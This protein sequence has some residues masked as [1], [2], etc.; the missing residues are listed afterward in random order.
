MGTRLLDVDETLARLPLLARE[1]IAG[2]L[3]DESS[4]D[5]EVDLLHQG[6]LRQARA[7]GASIQ[8]GERLV[9]LEREGGEWAGAHEQRRQLPRTALWSTR[10]APGRTRSRRWPG[11][12]RWASRRCAARRR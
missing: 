12:R 6:F 10:P 11:W 9:S 5:I 4:A 2:G 1:R 3:L 8:L 7:Q